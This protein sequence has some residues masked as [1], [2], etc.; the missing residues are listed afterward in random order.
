MGG[1]GQ[2]NLTGPGPMIRSGPAVDAR[3]VGGLELDLEPH[4]RP[5]ERT[6]AALDRDR[7]PV[8]VAEVVR[9]LMPPGLRVR[10]LGVDGVRQPELPAERD[11]L[12]RLIDDTLAIRDEAD[13]GLARERQRQNRAATERARH[14]HALRGVRL[15]SVLQHACEAPT[16][17]PPAVAQPH[18]V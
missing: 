13:R 15:V 12:A 16:Y 8:V 10:A 11:G 18:V 6:L 1:A 17:S 4:R 7:R 9:A 5:A 2:Q 3:S 14:H